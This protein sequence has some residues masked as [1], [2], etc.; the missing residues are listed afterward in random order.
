MRSFRNNRLQMYNIIF[1][2]D[3][4]EAEFSIIGILSEIHENSTVKI[5]ALCQ[6][7]TLA[8]C[9]VFL[10]VRIYLLVTFHFVKIRTTKTIN[11]KSDAKYL[12][13]RSGSVRICFNVKCACALFGALSIRWICV[14]LCSNFN[15]R[16]LLSSLEIVDLVN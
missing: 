16:R 12:N 1:T 2:V 13:R 4:N 3:Y 5:S 15:P 7:L 14:G 6:L 11:K 8:K 10:F 9:Q